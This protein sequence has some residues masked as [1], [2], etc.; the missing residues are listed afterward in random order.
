M[1]AQQDL[2]PE[3]SWRCYYDGVW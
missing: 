2:Q 3:L 1:F